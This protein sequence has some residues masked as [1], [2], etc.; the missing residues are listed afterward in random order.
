M[1]FSLRSV[2]AHEFSFNI[3]SVVTTCN[4]CAAAFF[5]TRSE[6][7]EEQSYQTATCRPCSHRT[8]MFMRTG[9]HDRTHQDRGEP[10]RLPPAQWAARVS[11]FQSRAGDRS[12]AAGGAGTEGLNGAK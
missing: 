6:K 11:E 8:A 5:P 3:Q 1:L 4:R 9:L 7:H 10:A 12:R 2:P